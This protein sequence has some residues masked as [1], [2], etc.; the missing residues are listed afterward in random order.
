MRGLS[1]PTTRALLWDHSAA[2]DS[3][4]LGSHEMAPVV[5]LAPAATLALVRLLAARTGGSAAA[6]VRWECA[7]RAAADAGLVL[8]VEDVV[9]EAAVPLCASAAAANLTKAPLRVLPPPSPSSTVASAAA[10]SASAEEAARRL[11]GTSVE[12]A[13]LADGFRGACA[14]NGELSL[15]ALLPVR[16]AVC[17]A[18]GTVGGGGDVRGAVAGTVV[19]PSGTLRLT[20]LHP[21]RLCD[22]ALSR[23][24]KAGQKAAT[25]GAVSTGF[26]TLDQARKLL[27]LMY[28]EPRTFDLPLVGVWVAGV[29]H[30]RHPAVWAAVQRYLFN[31]NLQDKVLKCVQAAPLPPPPRPLYNCASTEPRFVLGVRSLELLVQQSCGLTSDHSWCLTPGVLQGPAVATVVRARRSQPHVL[32]RATVHGSHRRRAGLSLG[33]PHIPVLRRRQQRQHQRRCCRTR[34]QDLPR[35]ADAADVHAA[36]TAVRPVAAAEAATAHR[37]HRSGHGTARGGPPP[38]QPPPG[39]EAAAAG[40]SV[41]PLLRTFFD[42][43]RNIHLDIQMRRIDKAPKLCG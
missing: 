1:F 43:A 38:P 17:A 37:Q 14:S 5:R 29:S 36:V 20:P 33:V 21:L 6:L 41:A 26:L 31:A 34:R 7:P 28:S 2:G 22:T 16:L 25:C 27:P 8:A 9:D 19:L 13:T 24:L 42:S 32:R 12:A 15:G 35:G 10:R 18:E 4:H 39:R 30:P 11:L 3:V 23:S 40:R